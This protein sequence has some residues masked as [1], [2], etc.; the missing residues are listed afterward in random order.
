MTTS[1]SSE[2]TRAAVASIWHSAAVT[3]VPARHEMSPAATRRDGSGSGA[4]VVVVV[5]AGAV[6]VVAG[7]RGWGASRLHAPRSAS[8]ARTHLVGGVG[9]GFGKCGVDEQGLGDV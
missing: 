3:G 9:E 4:A 6:V 2:A 1:G 8:A 5:V 7:D